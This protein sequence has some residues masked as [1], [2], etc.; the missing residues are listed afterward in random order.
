MPHGHPNLSKLISELG[1]RLVPLQSHNSEGEKSFLLTDAYS[2]E[3]I[4]NARAEKIVSML[5]EEMLEFE[6]RDGRIVVHDSK[7]KLVFQEIV[8]THEYR[9]SELFHH[10]KILSVSS[11]IEKNES[12]VD[13]QMESIALA[14]KWQRGFNKD[15]DTLSLDLRDLVT[16]V[17]E[18]IHGLN[19]VD[20]RFCTSHVNHTNFIHVLDEATVLGITRARERIIKR[21]GFAHPEI[22]VMQKRIRELIMVAQNVQIGAEIKAPKLPKEEKKSGS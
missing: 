9:Y 19:D 6:E 20:A 5:V 8:D 13:T 3:I 16:P 1:I 7:T 14:G 10:G 2:G 21:I 11:I 4:D 22:E 18:L 17:G 15:S 12:Q